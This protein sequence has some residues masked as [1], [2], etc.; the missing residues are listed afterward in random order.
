MEFRRQSSIAMCVL[1]VIRETGDWAFRAIQLAR[2]TIT[3]TKLRIAA[4]QLSHIRS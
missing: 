3:G 1:G 4:N 2:F